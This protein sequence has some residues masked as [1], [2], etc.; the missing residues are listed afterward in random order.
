MRCLTIE[1]DRFREKTDQMIS[2]LSKK[3][4]FFLAH[5]ADERSDIYMNCTVFGD[6]TAAFV[7]PFLTGSRTNPETAMGVYKLIHEKFFGDDTKMQNVP[8]PNYTTLKT[9]PVNG[10]TALTRLISQDTSFYVQSTYLYRMLRYAPF[11]GQRDF[12]S[13]YNPLCMWANDDVVEQRSVL[14]MLMPYL[15][16]EGHCEVS[17]TV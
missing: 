11:Q 7:V 12:R 13:S 15:P 8:M 1:S 14:A 10:E 17:G 16:K 3:D 2:W 4:G 9:A 6:G 5:P